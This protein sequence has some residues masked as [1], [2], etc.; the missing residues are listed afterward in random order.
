[1]NY[2]Q[3]GPQP[4]QTMPQAG[5]SHLS[6]QNADRA[7][8]GEKLGGYASARIYDQQELMRLRLNTLDHAAALSSIISRRSETIE[9][10]DMEMLIST[11]LRELL[12]LIKGRNAL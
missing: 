5:L 11:K 7:Y 8:E 3:Q 4:R 9:E 2:A 12:L 1:M 10:A 6:A